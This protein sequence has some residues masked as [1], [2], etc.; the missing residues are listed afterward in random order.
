[1]S[2]KKT[3]GVWQRTIALKPGQSYEFRYLIDG[4]QWHNET[5]ADSFSF[6]SFGTKNSV[7]EI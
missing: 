7:V 4:S 5:E 3:A 6:N 1:M 2:L